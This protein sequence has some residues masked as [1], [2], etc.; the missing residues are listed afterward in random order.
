MFGN[1]SNSSGVM[2]ES[3]T[4]IIFLLWPSSSNKQS[5]PHETYSPYEQRKIFGTSSNW[6][7]VPTSFSSP[8][9]FL[10]HSHIVFECRTS[11]WLAGGWLVAGCSWLWL[12]GL[13]CL[14]W[15][16]WLAG[17]WLCGWLAGAWLVAGW[18]ADGLARWLAGLGWLAGLAGW[19]LAGWVAGWLYILYDYGWLVFDGCGLPVLWAWIWP[20]FDLVLDLVPVLPLN[21]HLLYWLYQRKT[22]NIKCLPRIR[23]VPTSFYKLN[24]MFSTNQGTPQDYSSLHQIKAVAHMKFQKGVMINHALKHHL[25]LVF[26]YSGSGST[27]WN[28]IQRCNNV[29]R[30]QGFCRPT[31]PFS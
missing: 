12:A 25:V 17:C 10:P 28:Q 6:R 23:G 18:L 21:L 24:M 30:L 15:L 11:F 20:R 7:G 4:F 22:M 29:Y 13:G 9:W 8:A 16:A 1:S 14:G 26:C 31:S 19:L 5:M 3:A 27:I 2:Q